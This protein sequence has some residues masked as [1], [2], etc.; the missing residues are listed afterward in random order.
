MEKATADMLP[1]TSTPRTVQPCIHHGSNL[2]LCLNSMG[3]KPS[4]TESP[5]LRSG[6]DQS[7]YFQLEE[8]Q[9]TT[10]KEN[11]YWIQRWGNVIL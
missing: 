9:V 11:S 3:Q 10:N 7:D 6:Q 5:T 1:G 2:G 8:F 4:R